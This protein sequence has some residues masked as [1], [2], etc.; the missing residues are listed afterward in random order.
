V[1]STNELI[2]WDIAFKTFKYQKQSNQPAIVGLFFQS[3]G[4]PGCGGYFVQLKSTFSLQGSKAKQT[5]IQQI[6][7][8]MW[9][10][11]GALGPKRHHQSAHDVRLLGFATKP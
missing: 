2:V 4:Y 1:A 8:C 3:A 7:R 6:T 10:R 5:S 11:N 9:P